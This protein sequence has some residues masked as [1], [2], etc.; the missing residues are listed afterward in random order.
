MT[1]TKTKTKTLTRTKTNAF[2][3]HLQRV[4]LETCDLWDIWSEW[5]GDMTWPTK[6]TM[7]KTNTRKKTMTQALTKT[8]TKTI[9]G[10]CDIW[11]TNYHS[12]NWEPEFMTIFVSWQLRVTLDS[13]PNSCDV[14]LTWPKSYSSLSHPHPGWLEEAPRGEQRFALCDW[15]GHRVSSSAAGPKH[16]CLCCPW[17]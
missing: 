17:S 14:F 6:K 8:V 12:D 5:W 7:T 1:K 4:A 15:A 13:I 9:P 16:P 11:D 2:R 10:P 3:E